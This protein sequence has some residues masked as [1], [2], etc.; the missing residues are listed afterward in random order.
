MNETEKIRNIL[1]K[2]GYS[3]KAIVE[4]MKWYE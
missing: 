4:I 2:S 1:R 3:D